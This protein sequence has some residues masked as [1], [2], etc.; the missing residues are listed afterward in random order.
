MKKPS[1]ALALLAAAAL[2]GTA[3]SAAAPMQRPTRVTDNPVSTT[4]KVLVAVPT[5]DLAFYD[6]LYV[7]T[8]NSRDAHGVPVVVGGADPFNS[9]LV[10]MNAPLLE[11]RDGFWGRDF[12]RAEPTGFATYAPGSSASEGNR[13]LGAE[14]ADLRGS[15]GK[16]LRVFAADGPRLQDLPG[17]LQEDPWALMNAGRYRDAGAVFQAQ[18]AGPVRDAGL[19]AAAALSGNLDA[20]G[21]RLNVVDAAALPASLP[22]SPGL[23]A[24]LRGLA[25][26]MYA[27]TPAAGV[28]ND[29]ADA[30]G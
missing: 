2:T 4:N 17:P 22:V 26:G 1:P 13:G 19:A 18:A 12:L 11:A 23:A 14:T 7:V 20:A 24:R 15:L 5:E 16:P 27:G 8:E 9:T 21:E 6:Y 3:A 29:L 30:G 25:E 10:M 28:L